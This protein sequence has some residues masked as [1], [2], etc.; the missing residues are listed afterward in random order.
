MNLRRLRR[1]KLFWGPLFGRAIPAVPEAPPRRPWPGR[2]RVRLARVP[3]HYWWALLLYVALGAVFVHDWDGYVFETSVRDFW[4]GISPYKVGEEGPYYS[5]LNPADTQPQWYAYPPLPLLLMTATFVPSLLWHLPPMADRVLLKVPVILG[6]LALAWVCGRW[7]RHLGRDDATVRRVEGLLLFNPFLILVGPVWGMTDTT[8]MAFLLG[9]ALLWAHRRYGWAGVCLA[10][11]ALIKPFPLLLALPLLAYYAPRDGWRAIGRGAATGAA[12]ALAVCLPFVVSS[13]GAFWTQVVGVHLKRD[14]QG[15][16][17]W[18]V[19]SLAEHYPSVIAALSVALIAVSLFALGFL[20]PRMKDPAAPLILVVAASAQI[21]LWNRVVNEQY[22]VMAIAPL[23]VLYGIDAIPG[24]LGRRAAVVLP[25]VFALI[26]AVRGFHFI[27]FIP[28]DVEFAVWGTRDVTVLANHVRKL[29]DFGWQAPLVLSDTTP[30]ILVAALLVVLAVLG[31]WLVARV[32][33]PRPSFRPMRARLGTGASTFGCVVLLVMGATPLMHGADASA[34][35]FPPMPDRPL[36]G[37]FYYLWWDNPAHD[38]FLDRPYGNWWQASE[39]SQLGYYTQTRGV[40]RLHAKMMHDHGID[41]A[42][43]SFHSSELQRYKTFEEEAAKEGVLVAPLIELNQVY[44]QAQYRPYAE[45]HTLYASE[46]ERSQKEASYSLTTATR[47]AIEDYVLQLK[48]TFSM[49]NA[50][51]VNGKAVIMFYD[52]YVSDVGFRPE[53]RD[54]L[55]RKLLETTSIED[56]R[57]EFHDPGLQPTVQAIEQY[58][59]QT[60]PTGLQALLAQRDY[61]GAHQYNNSAFVNGFNFNNTGGDWSDHP[62]K[63]L[64]LAAPWRAAHFALHKEWWATLRADLERQVGP[65]FLVSGD[66]WNEQAAFYAGTIKN[67]ENLDDFDGSF[68]YSPSFTWGVQPRDLTGA[69]YERYFQL[70]TYRNLWLTSFANAMGRYSTFGT[71]PGYDDTQLCVRNHNQTDN[72]C[73]FRRDPYNISFTIPRTDP[74][75]GAS[76]YDLGWQA[77]IAARPSVVV[78]ATFNEFFEGSAIEPNDKVGTRWLDATGEYHARFAA[79]GPPTRTVVNVVHERASRLQYVSFSETDNPHFWG[80]KQ[81]VAS[82]ALAPGGLVEAVDGLETE[83]FEGL[84]ARPDIV[85]VDGGRS[86]YYRLSDPVL[87]RLRGWIEAG[88]PTVVFGPEISPQLLDLIPTSCRSDHDARPNMNVPVD[89]A[90]A[91]AHGGRADPVYAGDVLNA[92]DGQVLLER[93]GVA[94]SIVVG[95][96]CPE[97]AN[98]A[99]TSLKPWPYIDD[100][101]NFREWTAPDCLATFVAAFFPSLEA[102]RECRVPAS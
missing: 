76:T 31:W 59:P 1:H 25:A 43:V 60:D 63:T 95:V 27:R 7:A 37:A 4:H 64:R 2:L 97:K 55:A 53:E 61:A 102:S 92:T 9:G 3:S 38:P 78:V 47:R 57:Y 81:I 86:D 85:L 12:F 34:T 23:L 13:P 73:G 26:T 35:T 71:A 101:S 16:T 94:T 30:A 93:P 88:V 89:P 77:S 98:L 74:K 32:L 48:P 36:V 70:W 65:V 80:L 83:R 100:K 45:N 49:P 52:S 82:A 10:A 29:F 72:D 66:A 20:A 96:R 22:L 44:D 42:V 99:F 21:L 75:T 41:L 91:H 24:R 90:V 87:A 19:G 58:Y 56:L 33:E 84:P 68:I 69:N 6:S 5:Y 79:Q 62:A 18:S 50:Y 28:P 11:S 54:D 17:I 8:L 40:A 14:P 67:I 46:K 15:I 39:F 51:R